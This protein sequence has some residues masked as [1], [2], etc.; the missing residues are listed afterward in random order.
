MGRDFGSCYLSCLGGAITKAYPSALSICALLAPFFR[1]PRTR[2]HTSQAT[3]G[4]LALASPFDLN[5]GSPPRSAS[6][7][8]HMPLEVEHFGLRAQPEP[9]QGTRRQQRD[10]Q[11]GLVRSVTVDKVSRSALASSWQHFASSPGAA[12]F[13]SL[14]CRC[15]RRNRWCEPRSPADLSISWP[16]PG[17]L[18][19]L[20]QAM[21]G[22]D[23]ACRS[24]AAFGCTRASW[25]TSS[26]SRLADTRRSR[27]SR[28]RRSGRCAAVLLSPSSGGACSSS[29]FEKWLLLPSLCDSFGQLSAILGGNKNQRGASPQ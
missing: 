10:M 21:V 18:R 7:A 13:S 25:N 27:I 28:H 26:I 5:D 14:S 17:L 11:N 4:S 19:S 24:L 1:A 3:C 9:Q 20:W 6:A 2:I 15:C 16:T 29:R 23:A 8:P 12:S 22:A